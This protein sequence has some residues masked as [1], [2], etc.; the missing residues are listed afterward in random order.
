MHFPRPNYITLSHQL[1]DRDRAFDGGD[2]RGKLHEEAVV[3]R[4]DDAAAEAGHVRLRSFATASSS[5][6]S[7]E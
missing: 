4:L 3:R 5:P 6:M 7:C 1:L 2:H